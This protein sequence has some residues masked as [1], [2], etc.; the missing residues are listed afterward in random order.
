MS[1]SAQ[2]LAKS[3]LQGIGYGLGINIWN[4]PG[5]NGIGIMEGA[6]LVTTSYYH[7][8]QD[9][10][11]SALDESTSF[12]G[13]PIVIERTGPIEHLQGRNQGQQGSSNVVRLA[14][15]SAVGGSITVDLWLFKSILTIWFP[16][17]EA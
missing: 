2:N 7:P 14:P 5:I 10:I 3:Y 16:A 1:R 9:Q 15:L 12:E 6:I 11:P 8:D 17:S 13:L 4:I